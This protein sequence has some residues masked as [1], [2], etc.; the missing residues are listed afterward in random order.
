MLDEEARRKKA[1]KIVAVVRHALGVESLDGLTAVDVG[2][3]AGLHRRRAG[4]R[5]RHDERRRHR[6]ARPRE[7]AGPLR[8]PGRLPP[9]PR[10][11][12]AVRRRLG[13]RRRPQPHLRARRRPRGRRRRHPPGAAPGRGALPRHRAPLAGPR[14]APPAAVPVVAAAARRRPLHAAHPQGRAL[15]RALLHP[16]RAAPALRRLRR[17]GLHAAGPRRPRRLLRRRQRPGLVV[18][19]PRGRR[20]RRR[21]RWCPPT[22]GRRSRARPRRRVRP[23]ASPR[24]TSRRARDDGLRGRGAQQRV[25]HAS[26]PG[27]AR[28][29]R[30]HLPARR[31]RPDEPPRRRAAGGS[32]GARPTAR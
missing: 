1:A 7:G 19:G 4:A 18:A 20:S 24:A 27:P 31:G 28:G 23:C 6:R 11:G 8:R 12:P 14:A 15:L 32:P 30:R 2:C 16:G 13:R 3:S 26:R 22:C 25:V 9:R 5:G 17:L 10:R 21:C 29:R